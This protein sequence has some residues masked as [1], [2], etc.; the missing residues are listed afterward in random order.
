MDKALPLGWPHAG[1]RGPTEEEGVGRSGGAGRGL[2]RRLK[3][4]LICM[5]R[6]RPRPGP[7]DRRL[8]I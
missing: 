6:P 4:L 8:D 5:A 7:S 3:S 2:G 1:G